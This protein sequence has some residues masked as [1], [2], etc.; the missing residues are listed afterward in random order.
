MGAAFVDEG[1]VGPFVTTQL[2]AE[3]GHELEPARAADD[4]DHAVSRSTIGFHRHL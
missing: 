4:D 1:S 2:V 3:P